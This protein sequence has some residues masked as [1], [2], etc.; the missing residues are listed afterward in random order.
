MSIGTT[1]NCKMCSKVSWYIVDEAM[2]GSDDWDNDY[3]PTVLCH[4]C[5]QIIVKLAK[6]YIV[7]KKYVDLDIA[8]K[9]IK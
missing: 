4:A 9:N 8:I 3:M 7:A 2:Q 1:C 5:W 6:D